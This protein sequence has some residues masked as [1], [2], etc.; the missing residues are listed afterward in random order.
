MWQFVE[1]LAP[2]Y[3]ARIE[4]RTAEFA[5][6]P[7]QYADFAVWQHELLQR[8][9]FDKELSYWKK[10][11]DGVPDSLELPT[12]RRRP[13]EISYRG[14]TETSVFPRALVD[15]LNE[16]GRREGAT[17][18]MTLLAAY[19]TLLYRYTGQDDVVV[20]SPIANRNRAETESLIG[21]FVNTLVMRTDVSGNPT[22][23][24]VLQ[25][26]REVALGAYANQDL[27]FEKLV[28]ALHPDRHLGRIPMFQ[29]WFALQNAP[30]SVW[31]L[32]GLELRKMEVHNG[33]SKFDL[34]LFTVEKPDGL[35][36]LVEYS[37]CFSTSIGCW[38]VSCAIQTSR[39]APSTC[40]VPQRSS[41][42]INGMRRSES[43]R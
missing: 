13:A 37:G 3:S 41:S 39:L 11:L 29:V 9:A 27:P 12:D 43:I 8:R 33:A 31:K 22:F 20:G 24:Q 18:Y 36:C 26:A 1:E 42:F 16:V 10:Q 14:A 28:E 6:L 32:E 35:H 25:R 30:P 23:R 34:G 19:Q 2:R 7:I 38:K 15:K 5:E 17:L 40:S 4:G 21:F